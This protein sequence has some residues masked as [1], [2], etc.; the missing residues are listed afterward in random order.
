MEEEQG[1]HID[2]GRDPL[3]TWAYHFFSVIPCLSSFVL[4]PSLPLC[5]TLRLTL[6]LAAV[7]LSRACRK[8]CCPVCAARLPV[9][10]SL[11][12]TLAFPW[13]ISQPHRLH[14]LVESGRGVAIA[15]ALILNFS[16][17]D[18]TWHWSAAPGQPRTRLN[19][20]FGFG[21]KVRGVRHYKQSILT[22]FHVL[23]ALRMQQ[24]VVYGILV[25]YNHCHIISQLITVGC[26]WNYL[27][28]VIEALICVT[29]GSQSNFI[30]HFV[31]QFFSWEQLSLWWHVNLT[32][33]RIISLVLGLLNNSR[34]ALFIKFNCQSG[35]YV[36][37]SL[38]LK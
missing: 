29:N 26:H 15:T 25:K 9:P 2:P 33:G 16:L 4:S 24:N 13:R 18:V 1:A 20:F 38:I 22:Q 37:T 11:C 19:G 10:H 21:L 27:P 32:N 6:L 12:R 17:L 23:M 35:F 30:I 5:A 3:F 34:E 31:G 14:W 7:P 28:K 8:V 36:V